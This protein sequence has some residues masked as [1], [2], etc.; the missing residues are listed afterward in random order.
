MTVQRGRARGQ[1]G[2]GAG[3]KCSE[4]ALRARGWEGGKC[5]SLFPALDQGAS[6]S[7]DTGRAKSS[8][9]RTTCFILYFELVSTEGFQN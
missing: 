9:L 8:W 7:V 5:G 2:E 1:Q 3:F 4:A 6:L